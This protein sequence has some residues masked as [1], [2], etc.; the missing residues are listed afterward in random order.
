MDG[1]VVVSNI[2]NSTILSEK[3]QSSFAPEVDMVAV[4]GDTMEEKRRER[5][6]EKKPESAAAGEKEDGENG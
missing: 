6:E 4:G 2:D 3:R 5:P 1:V